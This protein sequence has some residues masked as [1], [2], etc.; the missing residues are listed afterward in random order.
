MITGESEQEGRGGRVELTLGTLDTPSA[1][2]TAA[3]SL[4]G[5]KDGLCVPVRPISTQRGYSQLSH[6]HIVV[7][8]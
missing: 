5:S 7:S 6:P 8:R 2:D 4:C 3:D 1:A